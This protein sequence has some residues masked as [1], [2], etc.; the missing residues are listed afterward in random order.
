[1]ASRHFRTANSF[2]SPGKVET[3][4]AAKA[5]GLEPVW[6]IPGGPTVSIDGGN[7]EDLMDHI[8]EKQWGG[9]VWDSW[10]NTEVTI[11]TYKFAYDIKD[12]PGWQQDELE[13][14]NLWGD[15]L[16]NFQHFGTEQVAAT[17]EA[18]ARWAEVTN[19]RFLQVDPDDDADIVFYGV[20][21]SL[22]N[23]QAGGQSNGP[24][25]K[26]GTFVRLGTDDGQWNDTGA[27]GATQEILIHE[28]GHALGLGHPGDYDASDETPPTYFDDAEYIQDTKM[29]TVM[30]YFQEE[31]TG[32]EYGVD[33]S[34]F[35]D[36]GIATTPHPRH[37]RHS[38]EVRGQ[39]GQLRGRHRL[40]LQV[41]GLQA[42]TRRTRSTPTISTSTRRRWSPSGM[43]AATTR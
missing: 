22:M 27:G 33:Y 21:F 29:Y 39:L 2:Y 37:A 16:F 20:D 26:W 5:G 28:I 42:S 32:G 19:V 9:Q 34:D 36:S 14:K 24:D 11:L 8:D 6:E 38:A 7:L 3:T 15:T 30:S 40:R 17:T 13:Y 23:V 1:M 25:E 43:A 18:L 10:T 41:D 31:R 35:G 12:L 4:Q